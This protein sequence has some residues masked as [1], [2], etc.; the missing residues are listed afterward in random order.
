MST[1]SLFHMYGFL[2]ENMFYRKFS[3][4]RMDNGIDVSVGTVIGMGWLLKEVRCVIY[5]VWKV[6]KD[7]GLGTGMRDVVG[8]WMVR[9]DE[10]GKFCN[11]K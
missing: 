10:K 2:I 11:R 4:L 8:Y 3:I 6:L 7:V 5:M 1:Q 9:A